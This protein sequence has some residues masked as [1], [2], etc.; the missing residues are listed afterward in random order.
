MANINFKDICVI[1]Y[2]YTFRD[3]TSSYHIVAAEICG[4]EAT[5]EQLDEINNDKDLV[6]SLL[7]KVWY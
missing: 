4:V 3:D 5:E 1:D 6:W 2:D 7:Y